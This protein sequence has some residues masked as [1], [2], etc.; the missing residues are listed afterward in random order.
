MSKPVIRFTK[1]KIDKNGKVCLSYQKMNSK[2]EWDDYSMSCA[3]EPAPSFHVAMTA[4]RTHA[5]EMC[6]LPDEYTGKLA[7][8][9]VSLSYAGPQDTMGCVITSRVNLVRSNCPLILNSPHKI[10]TPYGT[11]EPD[12]ADPAALLPD[13]C[14]EAIAVLCEE[15]QRY[16]DGER[17][18]TECVNT[19]TGEILPN[20]KPRRHS[21]KVPE[22]AAAAG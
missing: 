2:G 8:F 19:S 15:A 1:I 3:D 6:E 11:S 10:E 18:Q 12:E 17:A 14:K 22:L 4:M 13:G 7:V 20:A 5:I 16:L 21:K 9:S